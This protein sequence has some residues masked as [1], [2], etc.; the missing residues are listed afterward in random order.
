MSRTH[1]PAELR[2]LV[3][4]RAEGRCEYCLIH[5]DDSFYGCEVDHIISEKHGGLTIPENLAY[6]CLFCNR[7]KG[8]DLGSLTRATGHLVRFFNPRIDGWSDHFAL[9]GVTISPLTAIGEVTERVFKFNEVE[10]L[11]ERKE[12]DAVGR[13]PVKPPSKQG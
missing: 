6:C 2:R 10:R 13:Y 1:V 12:L 3:A 5:E 4:L 11:M 9:D 7:C 8:S